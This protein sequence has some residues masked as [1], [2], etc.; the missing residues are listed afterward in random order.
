MN[1]CDVLLTKIDNAKDLDFG[2]IFSQS[3]ELFKKTWVQG[4][5]MLLLTFGLM[6]PF[7]VLMYLP[8]IG[9]GLTSPESFESG[10]DFNVALM[11]PFYLM[12]LV[13]VFFAMIIGFGLKSAF[14]RIC[15]IKD[16]NEA[17]S[18]D[19]FYFFKKPY[20]G[21]TIK[22]AAITFGIGMLATMLCV[23]PIIYAMVPLA[24]I[25]V[26]YAFNPEMTASDIVKVGFKLGNK[27]WLITFGLMFVA[28]LLAQMVGMIM[29]FVGV[30]ITASFAYLPFYFIYK[31][32]IGFNEA[33]IIDEIGTIQE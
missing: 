7:Y 29:C 20:L 15:R 18:D 22:L 33:H 21:K 6:I 5:V 11:I 31:E 12:I 3:I 30:F 4:L 2:T 27:K 24:L 25:N 10:G 1:K 8:L 17:T 26:I 28:G 32:S 14:F 16:F 23:F 19:Y 9:M 13:F